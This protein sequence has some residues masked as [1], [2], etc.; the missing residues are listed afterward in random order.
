MPLEYFR[1]ALFHVVLHTAYFVA[2][3]K[4]GLPVDGLEVGDDSLGPLPCSLCFGFEE[5]LQ[6]DKVGAEILGNT[7]E[8]ADYVGDKGGNEFHAQ[9]E[10]VVVQER[11]EVFFSEFFFESEAAVG[12]HHGIASN[13]PYPVGVYSSDATLA[14]A[15]AFFPF[16][17][18][19]I[20]IAVGI[21]P[22]L[23]QCFY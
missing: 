15:E 2:M 11:G 22:V 16:V 12:E 8:S 5:V 18:N 7:D 21:L 20:D 14:V 23:I 10:S 19:V 9:S 3:D 4:K 13:W 6:V 1:V 17:D